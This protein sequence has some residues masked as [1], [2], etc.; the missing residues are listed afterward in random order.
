MAGIQLTGL[1]SGSFD[2]KSI[3]DQLI[4]ID[5]APVATLQSE[6]SKNIDRLASFS[7]LKGKMADLQTSADALKA[8]GLFNARTAS[9][10]TTGSGWSMTAAND[11]VTGNYSIDVT[12][13]ATA[14]RLNGSSAISQALSPTDDVSGLTVANMPTANAVSAG[15]FTVNGSQ[16][17]VA[18]T[19]SLQDV[20]N[21][22]STAT[23][24]LVTA[25]YSAATD[26]IT[27][28]SSDASEVVLGA[29]NDSSNF[30]SAVRL[31]NNGTGTLSSSSALGSAALN[32]PLASARLKGSF[33]AVDG[34]GNG[35]FAVNGVSIAYNI[36]TDS[37]STVLSRI[38]SSTAGVTASYD[39][40]SDR[41]VL[42]NRAT[43]DSGVGAS[44]TTGSLLNALGLGSGGTLQ[45]GKNALFSVDGG[46]TLSSMSNSLSGADH[47]IVGL[48]VN[49]NSLGAQTINVAPATAGMSSAINDFISKFNGVQS[50]IDTQ[51]QIT[52]TPDGKVSAA[53]LSDNH[54]VQAWASELRSLAFNQISGLTGTVQRL[55]DMGLDFN[56]T[57]STL[58]IK[59]QSKLTTAL[60]NQ[61]ADVGQFFATAGTG[62]AV[63]FDNYLAPKLDI[64]TGALATQMGTLNKA[65]TGIEAQ[66]ATLNARLVNQREL[67]TSSFIAM[68]NAQSMAQQQQQ[69]LTNMFGQK[70]SQ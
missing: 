61:S 23:S 59:D 18:L 37:L 43:G 11:A 45:H 48:T 62:F 69:Q 46:G 38:S 47:G 41:V 14:A 54:E 35:A 27:L 3:V 42:A 66:I 10:S 50:Y 63:A 6:E 24:G 51:T 15:V 65:N 60:A 56:S 13:L 40:A 1:I 12:R 39:L 53:L 36:N 19:D 49:V 52:K 31:S 8:D 33:G 34:S 30:L 55:A 67:L 20:F 21:K 5:S 9:S 58:Q 7:T 28:A 4:Q 26:K 70:N 25:S 29:G 57:D 17:T 44:D 2:W 32:V 16:V 68:Q 22:I 64:S